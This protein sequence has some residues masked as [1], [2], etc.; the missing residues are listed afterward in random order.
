MPAT[1]DRRVADRLIGR[2]I[3]FQ[4]LRRCLT[5]KQLAGTIEVTYQQLQK[6]ERAANRISAS[7]LLCIAQA[8]AFPISV[9]FDDPG[10]PER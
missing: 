7:R 8:L 2:N 10:S 4:R 9:F 6:Y 5:Q 3:R 1:I